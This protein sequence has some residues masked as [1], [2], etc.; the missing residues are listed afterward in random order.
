MRKAVILLLSFAM[1]ASCSRIYRDMPVD[2]SR[3]LAS[4]YRLYQ[5]T[6]AW[7]LAKAVWDN[8]ISK[9][10]SE[11]RKNPQLL[12]Y[13]ESLY[14]MSLLHMSSYNGQFKSFKELLRLGANP[15]IYDSIRCTSPIIQCCLDFDDKTKYVAELIKYGANVNDVECGKGRDPQKTEFTPIKAA[16]GYSGNLRI[17]KLLVEKGAVINDNSDES[18]LGGAVIQGYYDIVLYLLQQGADCNK[19]LYRQGGDVNNLTDIYMKDRIM[20]DEK[21]RASKEYGEIIEI[22]KKKGCM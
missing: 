7:E 14:G 6:P 3:L 22:L 18:I 10:D 12:N 1:I 13:Q 19:V 5:D 9:I 8:N 20:V 15:N 4:D 11:V 2:K 17:V 16:A 21:L